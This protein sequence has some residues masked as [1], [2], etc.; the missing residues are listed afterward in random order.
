MMTLPSGIG[1]KS[2]LEDENFESVIELGFKVYKTNFK[3]RNKNSKKQD[4][5]SA[6]QEGFKFPL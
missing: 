4:K 3:Q 5:E 2:E 6:R 1:V